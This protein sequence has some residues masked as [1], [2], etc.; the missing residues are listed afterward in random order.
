MIECKLSLR[1]AHGFTLLLW[2]IGIAR[3]GIL[4][5]SEH[6]AKGRVVVTDDIT[7]LVLTKRCMLLLQQWATDGL[8]TRSARTR[9]EKM[10][11]PWN[12]MLSILSVQPNSCR[13]QPSQH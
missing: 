8:N 4:I 9:L 6:I 5:V 2:Q 1:K 3:K 7:S 10:L 13:P 11:A 12:G